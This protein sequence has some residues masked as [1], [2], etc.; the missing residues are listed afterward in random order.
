MGTA[1]ARCHPAGPLPPRRATLGCAPGR[2]S[3]GPPLVEE[4]E[5]AFD[6]TQ[7]F[8]R[9]QAL[10]NVLK[11]T[12]S[13]GWS[14]PERTAKSSQRQV[15]VESKCPELLTNYCD[16]L[17]TKSQLRK[18]LTSGEIDEKLNNVLLVLEYVNSNGGIARYHKT[19]VNHRLILDL[20]A[21]PREQGENLI[22]EFRH[23]IEMSQDLDFNYKTSISA[24]NDYRAMADYTHIKIL[25]AGA[26]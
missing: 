4:D 20:M 6:G 7:T 22:N 15:N 2:N 26:W 23:D 24:N 9:N 18:R 19:H 21:A 1:S 13:A 16:L 14:S 25:N 3:V 10:L 11:N 8:D 12:G 17:P 5:L